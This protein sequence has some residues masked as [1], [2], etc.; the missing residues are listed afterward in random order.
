MEETRQ[1]PTPET[2]EVEATVVAL[3]PQYRQAKIRAQDGFLYSITERTLGVRLAALREGQRVRATVTIALPR[4][5]SAH[6][7]A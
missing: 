4:V 6:V 3:I 2:R 7:I 1:S 5:L